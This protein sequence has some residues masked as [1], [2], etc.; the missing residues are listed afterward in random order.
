[1]YVLS[2][3]TAGGSSKSSAQYWCEHTGV[4]PFAGNTVC[5][6]GITQPAPDSLSYRGSVVV[7]YVCTSQSSA[8]ALPVSWFQS[9]ILPL[10]PCNGGT[11]PCHTNKWS[12]KHLT[13]KPNLTAGAV[14]VGFAK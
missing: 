12:A 8:V 11:I 1:M 10:T 3:D 6:E 7:Q 9:T 14:Q 13:F 2:G 5:L 4:E